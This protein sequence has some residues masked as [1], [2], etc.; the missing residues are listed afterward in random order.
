LQSA[1]R[2]EVESLPGVEAVPVFVALVLGPGNVL[3]AAKVHFARACSAADIERVA[4]EAEDRL[5]A[6]F[7]GVRYV[8]LD[9]TRS[10]E[11]GVTMDILEGGD[12]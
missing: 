6:R 12:S 1:L 7:P 5:R 4:D 10:D 3:V 9:P 2:N 11:G 8:F